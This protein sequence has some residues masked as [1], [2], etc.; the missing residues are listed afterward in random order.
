MK[1]LNIRTTLLFKAY[2]LLYKYNCLI[3]YPY[4]DIELE[5]TVK[6]EEEAYK[7]ERECLKFLG[8]S[9]RYSEKNEKE[10][11]ECN[12]ISRTFLLLDA[13]IRTRTNVAKYTINEFKMAKNARHGISSYVPIDININEEMGNIKLIN[14]HTRKLKNSHKN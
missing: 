10:A 1:K 14:T 8:R 6:L 2:Y 11:L 7:I 5:E 12:N 4:R 3:S 13:L 9:I